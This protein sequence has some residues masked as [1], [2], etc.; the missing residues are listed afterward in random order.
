[1]PTLVVTGEPALGAIVT[2]EI[3]DVLT[4][5]SSQ[6]EV[7]RIAGAGHCVRYQQPQAFVDAVRVF[8]AAHAL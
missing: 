1:M 6:I 2:P 5:L 8:L 3:A 4:S 7:N